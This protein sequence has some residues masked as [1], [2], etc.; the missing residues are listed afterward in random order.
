MVD[1]DDLRTH[2]FLGEPHEY[3]PRRIYSKTATDHLGQVDFNRLRR[4]RLEKSREYMK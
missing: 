3:N 4:Q 2:E 1:R